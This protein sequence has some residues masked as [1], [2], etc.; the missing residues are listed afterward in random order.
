MP[1]IRTDI[2]K[3]KNPQVFCFLSVLVLEDSKLAAYAVSRMLKEL[4]AE[5]TLAETGEKARALIKAKDFDFMILDFHLPDTTGPEIAKE[6]RRLELDDTKRRPLILHSSSVDAKKR[7]LAREAGINV[8]LNK[9]LD[10]EGI[11]QIML[12]CKEFGILF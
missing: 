6:V 5:V 7:E 4:G 9:P 10:E 2:L 1:T 12:V 3:S 8:V 11:N